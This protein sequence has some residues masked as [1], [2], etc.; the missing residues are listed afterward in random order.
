MQRVV[1]TWWSEREM[2]SPA[3]SHVK[4]VI[5]RARHPSR[6][7]PRGLPFRALPAPVRIALTRVADVTKRPRGEHRSPRGRGCFHLPAGPNHFGTAVRWIFF[8]SPIS[9]TLPV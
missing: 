9:S 5:L 2:A 7:I 6:T 8:E 1:G 4:G 3:P